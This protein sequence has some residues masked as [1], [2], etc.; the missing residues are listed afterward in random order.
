M[1][2]YNHIIKITK[3]GKAGSCWEFFIWEG[4]FN[5]FHDVL[6]D[7]A[8]TVYFSITPKSHLCFYLQCGKEQ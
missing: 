3:M 2:H 5:L 4:T 1:F 8:Q 6:T 7:Y